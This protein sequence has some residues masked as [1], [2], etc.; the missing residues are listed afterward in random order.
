MA[1]WTLNRVTIWTFVSVQYL[2]SV[3]LCLLCSC[4]VSSV[5]TF[6]CLLCFWTVSWA[7]LFVFAFFLCSIFSQYIFVCCV[8]LVI[9][10][11]F[12]LFLCSIFSQYIYV[13]C[14]SVQYLEPV[15]FC[16]LCFCAIPSVSTVMPAVFLCTAFMSLVFLSSIWSP[17]ILWWMRNAML[18][19]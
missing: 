2:Q 3:R 8:S 16:L 11:E 15:Y 17:C 4:A 6:F 9:V 19:C 1:Y 18:A 7:S 5:S 14:V 13:C 10:L 12:S